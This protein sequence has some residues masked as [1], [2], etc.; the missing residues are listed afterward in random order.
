MK[1][2]IF[3]TAL[4][5]GVAVLLSSCLEMNYATNA[6]IF[7]YSRPKT[8]KMTADISKPASQSATV[9]FID[10]LNN[11]YFLLEKWNDQEIIDRLY[12]FAWVARYT[13]KYNKRNDKA[14]LVVPAGDNNFFFQITFKINKSVFRDPE[15]ELRYFFE[16]GKEY[17]VKGRIE[18]PGTLLNAV[19]TTA[20]DTLRNYDIFVGIYEVSGGSET[21][22]REWNLYR[23]ER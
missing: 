18:R 3:Q 22:L 16:A 6:F 10:N 20:E 5:L 2:T 1:K 11:G 4:L 9:T 17:H 7:G 15:V 12:G 19:L 23:A 8:F 14:I 13:S 21:L